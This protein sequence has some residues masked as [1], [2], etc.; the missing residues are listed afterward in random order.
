MARKSGPTDEDDLYSTSRFGVVRDPGEREATASGQERDDGLDA[1]RSMDLEP[2][3]ESPFLRAQKRVPVRRGPLPKKTVHRLKYLLLGLLALCAL[4]AAWIS[5]LRYGQKSWRFRLE[6]SDQIQVAG[7]RNVQRAQ[8]TDVF[9]GDISRNVFSIPLSERK[10]QVE[11]IPWVESATVMRLLPNRLWVQVKERTPAAFVQVRRRIALI[12]PAGVVMDL[13]ANGL[14]KYSFPV[15]VG[16]SE[17]DPLSIR[18][19]R[20]KSYA[21]LVRELDS[22]GARYSQEV[23]EIDVTDPEDAKVTVPD[24]AGEVLV[25]LGSGSYQERYKIFVANLRSWRQQDGNVSSV[26]LRYYPQVIVNPDAVRGAA[27]GAQKAKTATAP[28][29][30]PAAKPVAKAT[31][32]PKKHR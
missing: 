7:N 18:A 1:V 12:D 26:D 27:V 28:S 13:P 20:M 5:L 30:A 2:E 9:G 24:S 4:G 25:H 23:S 31:A 17:T 32:K 6:S 14:T 8:V 3:Q 10:R 19:A 22:G 29:A 16:M 21:A 11:E 15:L